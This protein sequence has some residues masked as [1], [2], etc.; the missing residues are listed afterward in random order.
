MPSKCDKCNKESYPMYI[1]DW[2]TICPECE[3][4]LRKIKKERN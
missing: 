3:D 4:E 1:T 2:G